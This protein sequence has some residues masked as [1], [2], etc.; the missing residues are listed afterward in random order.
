MAFV[1]LRT[2]ECRAFCIKA[3]ERGAD[4][5]QLDL[6]DSVPPSEKE[7]ARTL[8]EETAQRVRQRGSDVVVRINRP[9]SL[10]VRDIEHS[11]VQGVD[12]LAI[13]KVAGPSHI[14]LLDELVSELEVSRGLAEGSVRFITMV[15]TAEA[16]GHRCDRPFKF[17]YRRGQHRRRR[18]RDGLWHGTLAETLLYPKQHMV[19]AAASPA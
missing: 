12:A 1:T 14:Q 19:I 16:F 8:V 7:H 2:R 5:I 18:F 11:V 9:L 10:A 6:E 15:E 17:T 3:H 4:V 13:T